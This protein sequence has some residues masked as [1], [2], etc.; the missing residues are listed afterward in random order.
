MTRHLTAGEA[1]GMD[2][3]IYRAAR[4]AYRLGRLDQQ[5]ILERRLRKHFDSDVQAKQLREL[6]AGITDDPVDFHSIIAASEGK[7][8]AF[9][10]SDE[11]LVD[12]SAV[13]CRVPRSEQALR[14]RHTEIC[15]RIST[16]ESECLVCEIF[17]HLAQAHM[18]HNR[19]RSA[20]RAAIGDDREKCETGDARSDAN[21][22]R[23]MWQQRAYL[24]EHLGFIA[25]Q[26]C[27]RTSDADVRVCPESG[28]RLTE[29]CL[30]CYAR[31]T[32]GCG[33]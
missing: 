26:F 10:G 24:R 12:P 30:S 3:D 29:F 33:W 32:Q 9:D 31:A 17:W 20:I 28:D 4:L 8:A 25:L 5:R 18:R 7:P 2:T 27:E 6:A 19:Y 23:K 14:E 1:N 13:N 15:P 22:I 21:E 11:G 16:P